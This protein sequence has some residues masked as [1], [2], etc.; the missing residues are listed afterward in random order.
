MQYHYVVGYDS[1]MKR[2]FVELDTNGYFP[3]GNVWDDEK[4]RQDFWGWTVPEDDSDEALLDQTL[5]NT[6]SY[7]IDTFPI[8]K[9][10][11]N[12]SA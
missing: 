5:L 4:Y 8:P 1:E 7:I 12:V 11:E 3:D 2:W 6:L 10:H 9:E